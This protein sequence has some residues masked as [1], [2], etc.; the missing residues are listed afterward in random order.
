MGVG[1]EYYHL[2]APV[3]FI[4][5]KCEPKQFKE[6]ASQL[7]FNSIVTNLFGSLAA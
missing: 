6:H 7:V 2:Q 5:E 3:L 1:L 4:C